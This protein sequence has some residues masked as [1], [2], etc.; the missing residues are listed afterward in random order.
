[1]RAGAGK[2]YRSVTVPLWGNRPRMITDAH[3]FLGRRGGKARKVLLR[4]LRI[5][6]VALH[7]LLC[8]CVFGG[9]S[10]FSVVLRFLCP[11]AIVE[12]PFLHILLAPLRAALRVAPL[13]ERLSCKGGC[14]QNP[15]LSAGDFA[16]SGHLFSLG[17]EK[18]QRL[19]RF[20][21]KKHR[22]HRGSTENTDSGM[23][24]TLCWFCVLCA[25][26]T[27]ALTSLALGVQKSASVRN[28]LCHPRAVSLW[29][30]SD[31]S[32]KAVVICLCRLGRFPRDWPCGRLPT[33][34]ANRGSRSGTG[35]SEPIWLF[36]PAG[37]P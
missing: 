5:D 8:F 13:P 35:T 37:F 36:P 33:T 3:G 20:R 28:H 6:E 22:R 4:M 18:P 11:H 14:K 10:V 26:R 25:L 15:P 1:M 31:V 23:R 19:R 17:E 9:V 7:K 32:G 34:P 30:N 12:Q 16:V 2:C 27:F 29:L 21:E 24:E